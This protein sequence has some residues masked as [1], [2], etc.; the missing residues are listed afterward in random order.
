MEN[1]PTNTTPDAADRHILKLVD[2]AQK[3][4]AGLWQQLRRRVAEGRERMPERDQQYFPAVVG[5]GV[6]SSFQ[7][8]ASY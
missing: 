5:D 1:K 7:I 2:E 4:G 6:R 3:N 8:N